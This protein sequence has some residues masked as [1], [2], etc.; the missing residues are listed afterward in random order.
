MPS[1]RFDAER[2]LSDFA[3]AINAN[4]LDAVKK[5]YDPQVEFVGP[6]GGPERG[7]DKFLAMTGSWMEGFTD[8]R[9]EAKQ[10]VQTANDVAI[11]QTCKARHTGEFEVSPGERVPATN[12]NV[13]LTIAE[14]L[15][16]NDQGRIVRDIGIM[17][18]S[19]IT[20]QLGLTPTPSQQAAARKT[21][22]R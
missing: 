1:P 15:T 8:T 14:F 12:K 17:D 2:F 7:L 10:I 16:L 4:D 11:L 19:Q 22:Q 20:E 21:V 3:R 5:Y 6:E 9:I 13:E 18:R